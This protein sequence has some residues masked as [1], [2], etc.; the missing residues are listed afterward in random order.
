MANDHRHYIQEYG[1]LSFESLRI[2]LFNLG[3]QEHN[4]RVYAALYWE[5]YEQNLEGWTEYFFSCINEQGAT[6]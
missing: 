2:F 5:E 3:S 4:R 1:E 6:D